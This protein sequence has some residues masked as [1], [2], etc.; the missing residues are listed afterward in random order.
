MK[1]IENILIPVSDQLASRCFY[2]KLGF[3]IIAEVEIAEGVYWIQLAFDS[4]M[5][6]ISLVK[7]WPFS[8]LVA[9]ALQGLILETDNISREREQLISMGIV[10][11]E[12]ITSTNGKFAFI[13][14]PDRNGLSL[15]QFMV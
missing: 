8:D 14:D 13:S 2:L 4:Q 7:N 9:G 15:H 5:I 1:A 3:K 10:V 6:T 12:I 11:S